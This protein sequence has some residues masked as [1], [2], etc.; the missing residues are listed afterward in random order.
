[1]GEVGCDLTRH[2]SKSLTDLPA[3]EFDAVIGMGCGDEGCAMVPARRHE[4][5]DI[6]DPKA[7]P[8]EQYRVVRDLIECRVKNLLASL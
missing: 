1:M 3:V 7:L 8:A 5:W 4:Q 2:Q 6:P